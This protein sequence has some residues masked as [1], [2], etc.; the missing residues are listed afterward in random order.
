M[1]AGPHQNAKPVLSVPYV[2]KLVFDDSIHGV[3]P[4]QESLFENGVPAGV[5]AYIYLDPMC[6]PGDK[7]TGEY[8]GDYS[9]ADPERV[10]G[11]GWWVDVYCKSGSTLLCEVFGGATGRSDGAAY[12]PEFPFVW[13]D[14]A[15]V[16]AEDPY[17]RGHMWCPFPVVTFGLF[18]PALVGTAT[19]HLELR[20]VAGV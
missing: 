1:P 15:F 7:H 16:E 19:Y 8:L 18:N 3:L 20:A 17:F 9:V 12:V 6:G 5:A 10:Q 13:I 4:A 11:M 2:R 14:S